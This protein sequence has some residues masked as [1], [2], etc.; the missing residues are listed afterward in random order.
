MQLI[1]ANGLRTHQHGAHTD[2]DT[3]AMEAHSPRSLQILGQPMPRAVVF[4]RHYSCEC[5]AWNG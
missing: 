3:G 5:K 1:R 2:H 4:T